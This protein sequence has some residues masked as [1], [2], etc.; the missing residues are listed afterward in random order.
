MKYLSEKEKRT[1]QLEAL[2]MMDEQEQN[3]SEKMN[4]SLI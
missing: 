3:E 1:Q 2:M 4:V